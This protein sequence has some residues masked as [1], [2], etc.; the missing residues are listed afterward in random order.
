MPE[1]QYLDQNGNPVS[2]QNVYLD[3]NGNPTPVGH[4]PPD[5]TEQN[6]VIDKMQAEASQPTF[7]E[8]FLSGFGV[9]PEAIDEAKNNPTKFALKQA[10]QSLIMGPKAVYDYA[11]T[12]GQGIYEGG[13]EVGNALIAQDQG[14]GSTVENLVNAAHGVAHGV[15]QS[16]PF[17]G[18]AGEQVVSDASKGNV[19]AAAGTLT[20]LGLQGA[21]L[22]AAGS[23]PKEV[24]ADE[25]TTAKVSQHLTNSLSPSRTNQRWAPSVKAAIQSGDL[26]SAVQDAKVSDPV[27]GQL[28]AEPLKVENRA[29]FH[30]ALSQRKDSLWKGEVIPKLEAAGPV[31]VDKAAVLKSLVLPEQKS[32]SA[33]VTPKVYD[34][35]VSDQKQFYSGDYPMDIAEAQERAQDLN[36]QLDAFFKNPSSPETVEARAPKLAAILNERAALNE[37][38]NAAVDKMTGSGVADLKK[39]W[40]NLKSVEDQAFRAKVASEVSKNPGLAKAMSPY[41]VGKLAAGAAMMLTGHVEAALALG[42][43]GAAELGTK[44]IFDR[45]RNPDSQLKKA[46]GILEKMPKAPAAASIAPPSSA[47]PT[48]SPVTPVAA[49][50]AEPVPPRSRVGEI[51]FTHISPKRSAESMLKQAGFERNEQ[52]KYVRV[53]ANVPRETPTLPPNIPTEPLARP[54][55]SSPLGGKNVPES[56]RRLRLTP[57]RVKELEELSRRNKKGKK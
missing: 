28:T 56:F 18:S 16:V 53:K 26:A 20:A 51:D 40:G 24:V 31:P 21:A 14:K 11:K 22:R 47:Q 35:A 6:A 13:K 37:Q 29:Q 36:A 25:P 43:Y 15:A 41:M 52:G 19:G 39:R 46:V 48:P 1:T 34:N 49:P 12:A 38:I 42:T 30:D 50:Q 17:V 23:S 9:T 10:G 45:F 33:K 2:H 54:E 55:P 57:E 32:I 4:P 3:A 5:P 27:T 44:I 7:S 8:R